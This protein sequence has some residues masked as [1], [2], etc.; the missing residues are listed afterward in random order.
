MGPYDGQI[1]GIVRSGEKLDSRLLTARGTG[2]IP[3]SCIENV[4]TLSPPA[5][6]AAVPLL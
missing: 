1:G 2:Q 3:S 4:K 5:N 6:H